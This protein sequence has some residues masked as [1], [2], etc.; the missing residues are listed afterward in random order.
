M[1]CTKSPVSP[2]YRSLCSRNGGSCVLK[3]THD[4]EGLPS[5]VSQGLAIPGVHTVAVRKMRSLREQVI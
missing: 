3:L 2:S 5:A 4:V 1:L